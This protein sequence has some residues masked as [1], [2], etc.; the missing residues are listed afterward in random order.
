MLKSYLH[1]Y[2]GLVS[3]TA[4][5]HYLCNYLASAKKASRYTKQD[6]AGHNDKG[7]DNSRATHHDDQSESRHD[8]N[9]NS[10]TTHHDDNSGV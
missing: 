9:G 10:R 5:S 6:E 3:L 2:F 1:A 8:A 4:P 7:H